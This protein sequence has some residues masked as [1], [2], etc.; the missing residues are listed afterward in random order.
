M[1]IPNTYPQVYFWTVVGLILIFSHSAPVSNPSDGSVG[2]TLIPKA[3]AGPPPPLL[4]SEGVDNNPHDGIRARVLE[5]EK[6]QTVPSA[7]STIVPERPRL[8]PKVPPSNFT[9]G[10]LEVGNTPAPSEKKSSNTPPKPNT[11]PNDEDHDEDYDEDYDEDHFEGYDDDDYEEDYTDDYYH[12]DRPIPEH[13]HFGVPAEEVVPPSFWIKEDFYIKCADPRDIFHSH[14]DTYR[15]GLKNLTFSWR[16]FDDSPVMAEN[17]IRTQQQ[18]CREN[19]LCHPQRGFLHHYNDSMRCRTIRDAGKCEWLFGCECFA[20]LGNPEIPDVWKH[21]TPMDWFRTIMYLPLGIRRAHPDWRWTNG[22]RAGNQ[23]LHAGYRGPWT[24]LAEG[25]QVPGKPWDIYREVEMREQKPYYYLLGPDQPFLGQW[26]GGP[27]WLLLNRTA[28]PKYGERKPYS[29]HSRAPT[30]EHEWQMFLERWG[31]YNYEYTGEWIRR[32]PYMLSNGPVGE[33]N[34]LWMNDEQYAIAMAGELARPILREFRPPDIW[35]GVPVAP[36][37]FG[38][39]L[40][41]DPTTSKRPSPTCIPRDVALSN[42]DGVRDLCLPGEGEKGVEEG[43][44]NSHN[45]FLG[46]DTRK[47]NGGKGL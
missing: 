31:P 6:T 24:L 44:R 41:V 42:V 33:A 45:R 19:C 13:R 26:P 39:G 25:F 38:R 20:E 18:H 14:V 17:F 11:D 7:A 10:N 30:L 12:H 16:Q 46:L 47:E 22:P 21:F 32:K 29:E 34:G 36:G 5:A 2:V 23:T 43:S 35:Q 3:G 4:P 40:P 8:K 15:A 28:N 37:L 27:S 9:L 1:R